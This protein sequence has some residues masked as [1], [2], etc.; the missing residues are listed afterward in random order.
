MAVAASNTSVNQSQHACGKH[1]SVP[2]LLRIAEVA[3]KYTRSR[4]GF[5]SYIGSVLPFSPAHEASSEFIKRLHCDVC[6]AAS[7]GGCAGA[8][9]G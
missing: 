5:F 8:A 1:V 9:C 4:G 2:K 3:E 7:V 6:T